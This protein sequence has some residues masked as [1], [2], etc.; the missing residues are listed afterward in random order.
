MLY[1]DTLVAL[2]HEIL[3]KNWRTLTLEHCLDLLLQTVN[4]GTYI[5]ASN[6]GA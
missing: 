2:F 5:G 1:M 4:L 6:I 3:G